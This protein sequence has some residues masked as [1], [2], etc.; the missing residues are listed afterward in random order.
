MS[1]LGE[2]H[3]MAMNGKKAELTDWLEMRMS[4]KAARHGANEF[5]KAAKEIKKREKKLL[6]KN[7]EESDSIKL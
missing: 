6:F 4:K 7:I 5:I 2:I 1:K 3:D